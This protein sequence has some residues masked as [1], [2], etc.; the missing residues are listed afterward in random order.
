MTEKLIQRALELIPEDYK[1]DVTRF[2]C[3]ETKLETIIKYLKN[4]KNNLE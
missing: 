4:G 2:S 3:D 1:I